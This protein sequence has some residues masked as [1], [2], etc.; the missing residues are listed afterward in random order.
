MD[1]S[2]IAGPPSPNICYCHLEIILAI[3]T[4]LGIPVMEEKK[5]ELPTTVLTFLGIHL[6]SLNFEMKLRDDKIKYIHEVLDAFTDLCACS[7]WDL[8]S[9]LARLSF[10]ASVAIS[11]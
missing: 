6:D 5:T 3:Y 2:F 9:L 10:A 11:G 4:Y 8:L 1:N 7:N